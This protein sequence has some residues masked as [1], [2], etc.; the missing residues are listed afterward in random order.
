MCWIVKLIELA[1]VKGV[2]GDL[3]TPPITTPIRAEAWL[4]KDGLV[5]K[6]TL[7]KCSCLP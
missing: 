6:N 1:L 4:F 5:A 7:K 3:L 2:S